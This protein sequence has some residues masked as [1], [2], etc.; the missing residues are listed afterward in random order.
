MRVR[1]MAE[2]SFRL[3]G[4][5]VD[6]HQLAFQSIHYVRGQLTPEQVSESI[7]KSDPAFNSPGHGPF[8]ILH[9]H[10]SFVGRAQPFA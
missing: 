3:L 7:T 10:V 4:T 8:T 1:K 5:G 2:R 6:S 9:Q